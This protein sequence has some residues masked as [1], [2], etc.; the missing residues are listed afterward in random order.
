MQETRFELDGTNYLYLL[1]EIRY[2]LLSIDLMD[3]R[4]A[5]RVITKF[6]L[7]VWFCLTWLA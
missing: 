4:N 2:Y 6:Y 5:L 3:W 7:M 1:L